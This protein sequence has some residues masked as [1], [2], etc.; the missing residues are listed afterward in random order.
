MEKAAEPG[1][2]MRTRTGTAKILLKGQKVTG[3][4]SPALQRA[5]FTREFY[6]LTCK[7]MNDHRNY[8]FNLSSCEK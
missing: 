6:T 7:D 4:L 8:V 3:V 2:F 1:S 5:L